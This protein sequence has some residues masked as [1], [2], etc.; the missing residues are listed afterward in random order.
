[1]VRLFVRPEFGNPDFVYTELYGLEPIKKDDGYLKK[2][3]NY[4]SRFRVRWLGKKS[5]TLSK[6]GPKNL[7]EQQQAI[8]LSILHDNKDKISSQ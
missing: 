3:V 2:L 7:S 6:D 8:L 1:M 5:L 4:L